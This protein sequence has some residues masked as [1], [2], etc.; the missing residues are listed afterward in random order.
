MKQLNAAYR[1]ID[2][3]TDVLSF[4]Q[5]NEK[6][7]VRNKKC[8]KKITR[9]FPASHFSLPPSHFLLGDVVIN[10]QTFARQSKLSKR[11]FYDE[12][13]HLL[14]HGLLHLL[15][16]DHEKSKSRAF[17]MRKKEQEILNAIKKMG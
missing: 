4:P 5:V 16:Y 14:I 17:T 15:G 7:E 2:K 3:T 11:S 13:Y 8:N 1:G 9:I 10:I 6:W 12:I